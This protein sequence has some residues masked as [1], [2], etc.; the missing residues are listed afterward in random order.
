MPRSILTTLKA[1]HDLLRRLFAEI[2][3][4]S[5]RAAMT[6]AD[7]LERIEKT[8]VPHSRWEETVFYPAFVRRADRDGHR[9]HAE[10]LL[11][12]AVITRTVLPTVKASDT[13]TAEFAGRAK[14]FGELF[15]HHAREEEQTMFRLARQMFTSE[16]LVRMDEEYEAWKTS[17]SAAL[18]LLLEETCSGLKASLQRLVD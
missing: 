14:V 2:E 15:D 4:S 16:E 18:A 13:A 8:L 10:A 11:H 7:L 5:D 12:H 17:P 3:Q 1:E 6:R 9:A